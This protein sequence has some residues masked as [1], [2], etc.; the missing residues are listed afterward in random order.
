VEERHP[1]AIHFGRAAIS[2]WK[3]P[4]EAVP[5]AEDAEHVCRPWFGKPRLFDDFTLGL[6]PSRRPATVAAPLLTEIDRFG[7]VYTGDR[8]LTLCNGSS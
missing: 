2:P 1:R 5:T 7:S 4:A 6:F 3:E 8:L